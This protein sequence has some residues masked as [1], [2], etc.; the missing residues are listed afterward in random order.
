MRGL[1]PLWRS[2]ADAAAPVVLAVTF[3]PLIVSAATPPT[4]SPAIVG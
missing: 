1:P 2:V 3:L 4:A